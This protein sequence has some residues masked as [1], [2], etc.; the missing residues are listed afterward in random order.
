MEGNGFSNIICIGT[1]AGNIFDYVHKYG[2][3]PHNTF[4]INTDQKV[5]VKSCARYKYLIK[6]AKTSTKIN[7]SLRYLEST[8]V[9]DELALQLD[10]SS[11]TLI[12]VKIGKTTLD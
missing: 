11:S 4:S 8:T 7:K 5:L 2:K 3:L 10:S 1:T 12:V 9:V 6:T